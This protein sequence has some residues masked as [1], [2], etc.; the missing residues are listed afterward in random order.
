MNQE[1]P[2]LVEIG[3]V[4]KNVSGRYI[5][6]ELRLANE[7][8]FSPNEEIVILSKNPH[9]ADHFI[10]YCCD[11]DAVYSSYS[12]ISKICLM[13]NFEMQEKFDFSPHFSPHFLKPDN[14]GT[15]QNIL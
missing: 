11:I 12:S 7:F 1:K 9:Y 15:I 13:E 2:M 5:Q 3:R 4:Y 8:K 6:H 10:V 14:Y